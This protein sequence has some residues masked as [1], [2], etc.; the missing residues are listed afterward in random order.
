MAPALADAVEGLPREQRRALELRVL[1]QLPYEEV[2]GRLGC[3][4]NAARLRVSRA[5]RSLTLRLG[6]ARG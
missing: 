3:S 1:D 4:E 5:L 6:A 2:A